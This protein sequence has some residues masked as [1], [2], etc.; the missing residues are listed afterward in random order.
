MLGYALATMPPEFA[1]PNL[2]DIALRLSPFEGLAQ[3]IDFPHACDPVVGQW[4]LESEFFEDWKEGRPWEL[5]LYGNP[6]AGKV[7]IIQFRSSSASW[8]R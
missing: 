8:H 7:F 4:F 5:R 3:Q 1:K 2:T 6:G